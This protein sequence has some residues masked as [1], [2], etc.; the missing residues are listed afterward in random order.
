MRVVNAIIKDNDK[1][2][3]IKRKEGIHAGKW[4]FPGGIIEENESS[5]Q[6]LKR[7]IKEEL[8]L[9]IKKIKFLKQIF[10]KKDKHMLDD[11]NVDIFI[12]RTH[13]KIKKIHIKEGQKAKYLKINEIKKLKIPVYWKRVILQNKQKIFS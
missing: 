12:G 2:L 11:C 8:N 4:A 9:D 7:E 5:E 3:I 13:N 1:F 6:A 10:I